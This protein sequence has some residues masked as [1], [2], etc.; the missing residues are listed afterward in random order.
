MAGEAAK[1]YE[2]AGIILSVIQ[3]VF[4]Y[5]MYQDYKGKLYELA[6]KLVEYGDQDRAVYEGLRDMDSGF[7]DWYRNVRNKTRA[8]SGHDWM[9][10]TA[11]GA[12]ASRSKGAAFLKY[13]DA[14]RE[15]KASNKGYTPLKMVSANAKTGNIA[16]RMSAIRKVASMVTEEK[17]Q[18]DSVLTGWNAIVTAPVGMEGDVARAFDSLISSY[19]NSMK[20]A[21]QGFNSAG[22]MFGTAL[23]GL[24]NGW[25]RNT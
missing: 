12:R 9:T 3:M 25:N 19:T 24:T 13:G 10:Y 20:A 2:I 18:D 11:C 16:V 1:F 15:I 23:Y 5:R 17:Y 21:G 14:L 7:Y 6:D 22:A 4:Y 8:N